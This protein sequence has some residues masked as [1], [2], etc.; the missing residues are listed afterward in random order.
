MLY[1][2]TDRMGVVYHGT[3]FRW[4]EAGRAH[5]MR[6]RGASY[7]EV[8]KGGV[9]LP[10]VEAHAEYLRPARYDD[11]LKVEAWVSALGRAQLSFAYR[12]FCNGQELVQ[13]YTRHAAVN[14]KGRPVRLPVD[15]KEALSGA[16]NTEGR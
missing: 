15:I 13:G 11:V 6:Q 2:D 10:I 3:Y 5:F 12:I 8:E 9:F 16:P 7:A 14:R 1:A 4:F